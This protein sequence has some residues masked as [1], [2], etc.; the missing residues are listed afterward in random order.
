MAWRS[1]HGRGAG[2]PRIEVKPADEL[3]PANPGATAANLTARRN[4][5]R[6]FAKGNRAAAGRP[7]ALACLGLGYVDVSDPQY[8]RALRQAHS[9]RRRRV[10]ELAAVHGYVSAG[11]ASLLSSAALALVPW[12]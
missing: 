8:R 12:P 7:P 5:G 4:R 6:P 3:P 2:V 9:Y 11:A 10:S 1:G